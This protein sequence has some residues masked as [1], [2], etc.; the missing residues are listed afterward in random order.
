MLF[1]H[2]HTSKQSSTSHPAQVLH[3]DLAAAGQPCTPPKPSIRGTHNPNPSC[4]CGQ[5]R[6]VLSER[7]AQPQ[8]TCSSCSSRLHTWRSVACMSSLLAAHIA[9]AAGA[10]RRGRVRGTSVITAACDARVSRRRRQSGHN[11][12]EV[13]SSQAASCTHYRTG[14]KPQRTGASG[15]GRELRHAAQKPTQHQRQ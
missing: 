14:A 1:A 15:A 13:W 2:L 4:C 5:L 9:S 12:R 3:T 7:D 8:H 6:A 11:R 10:A